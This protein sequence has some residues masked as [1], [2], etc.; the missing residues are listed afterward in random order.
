M[1]NSNGKLICYKLFRKDANGSLHP[2]YI[3]AKD[4]VPVGVSLTAVVGPIA[5]DGKHVR[6]RLGNLAL[7][8]GWHCCEVPYAGHIGKRQ[9]SGELYQAKNTVWCEVEASGPDVTA[10]VRKDNPKTKCLKTL[11]NGFYWFQ[12]NP[13]AKIRWLIAKEI[14]SSG[15]SP[16]MRSRR[17]AVP[18]ASSLSRGNAEIPVNLK[19]TALGQCATTSLSWR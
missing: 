15:R 1:E 8:P 18:M 16:M 2:L 12:T 17:C 14:G 19:P 9:P 4:V 10:E 5:A 11:P 7:R 13:N 6:S 3:G